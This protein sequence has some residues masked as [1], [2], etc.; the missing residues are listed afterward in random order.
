MTT[1][2]ESAATV[3]LILV[4]G[5]DWIKTFRLG[6]RP[7]SESNVEYWD[8]TGW[9]GKSQIRKKATSATVLAD[10]DVTIDPEQDDADHTGLVTVALAAED[11][12]GLPASCVW[13]F[14]LTNPSGIK[15]TYMAG[16]VTVNREVTKES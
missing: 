15:R 3:D 4:Q 2:D 7:D 10:L 8:L 12:A 14:E 16:T 11:A 6:T 13:D 1:I 9:T 5:D